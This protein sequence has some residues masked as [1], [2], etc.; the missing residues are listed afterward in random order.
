VRPRRAAGFTLVELMISLA[1]LSLGLALAAQ[2]LA[3]SARMLAQ[4][5][6][7]PRGL[8]APVALARVRAEVRA[9]TGFAVVPRGSGE[10]PGLLLSG[11]PAGDVLYAQEGS[12]LVRQVVEPGGVPEEP[13][14]LMSGVLAWRPYV[15]GPHLLRI[16]L[17]YRAPARRRSPLAL[18][19]SAAGPA[20]EVQ[21][22]TLMLAPR[23]AGLGKRW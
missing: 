11:L 1:V 13:A 6:A 18:M 23:G 22:E 20:T 3:E 12:A 4:A 7:E 14:P 2:L 21:E 17:S 19:P 16:D 10:D 5:S 15:L 9:A 8:P